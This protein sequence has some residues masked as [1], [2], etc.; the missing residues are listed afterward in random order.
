MYPTATDEHE[1]GTGEAP[2]GLGSTSQRQHCPIRH[3]CSAAPDTPATDERECIAA[4]CTAAL[5]PTSQ[6]Q[7][8]T[9]RHE[10]IAAP[11]TTATTRYECIAAA[12]HQCPERGAWYLGHDRP[13]LSRASARI[14]TGT[15]MGAKTLI[16]VEMQPTSAFDR[17]KLITICVPSVTTESIALRTSP[18]SP[19]V[20]VCS[21][22]EILLPSEQT[23]INF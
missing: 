6:R 4:E 11:D 9:L 21:A 19:T 7:H 3:E 18:H 16:T 5:G 14:T 20:P 2:R 8:C 23:V 17:H 22:F 10:C 15:V 1:C 12:P 13:V